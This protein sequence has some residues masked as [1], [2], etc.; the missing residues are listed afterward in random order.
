MNSMWKLDTRQGVAY[1]E[2]RRLT[3]ELIR[4]GIAEGRTLK[5]VMA[6][7]YTA[8]GQAFAWQFRFPSAKWD[9]VAAAIAG[10]ETSAA[11]QQGAI[12]TA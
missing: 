12:P 2:D 7:Y 4:A 1:V 5:E 3:L 6:V 9:A 10:Q 11:P 8:K